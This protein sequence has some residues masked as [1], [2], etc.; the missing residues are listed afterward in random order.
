[1]VERILVALAIL[2]L[3]APPAHAAPAYADQVETMMRNYTEADRFSGVILV[4]K[5][6][7]PIFR[8]AYGLAN[9]EWNVPV[10]LDTRFRLASVTKQFTA[11]AI[12]QLVEQGKVSLDDP[13]SKYYPAA[14]EAWAPIT[15]KHLLTHSSGIPSYTGIQGFFGGPSRVDRTPEEIIAL[16]RDKPLEFKPGEKFAYNNTGYVL[17]GHVIAKVSGQTYQAYMQD[18]IFTPQG[19]KDTGYDFSE[20]IMPKRAAG[21]GLFGGKIG[22]APYL[23]MSLPH[24]AGSLYSTADDLLTWQQALRSGKVI[25]PASVTAMFTDQ[26]FEYGY[27]QFIEKR[28]GKRFWNHA[29]G[30]NGFVTMLALYPDDGLTIIVLS[31]FNSADMGRITRRLGE[32]YFHPDAGAG[33]SGPPTAA[34]LNRYVG[35]YRISDT[36]TIQVSREGTRLFLERTGFPKNELSRELGRSFFVKGALVHYTFPDGERAAQVTRREGSRE[37]V[38]NRIE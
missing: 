36:D 25:S 2:F 17:L 35:R 10:T 1:M 4:A 30:I 31:N 32:L 22:N 5:D 29:G 23:A 7:K 8:R 15:I 6:G 20:T 28:D 33:P 34:E 16:T 21:Y 13:V 19:L 26:G 37:T 24:A 9:R 38:A 12:L 18:Q 3:L 11:A 27:G 14:P